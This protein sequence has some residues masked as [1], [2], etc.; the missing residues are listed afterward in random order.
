M[1]MLKLPGLI[2]IHVHLR[3]PGATHKEDFE[4]GSRAAIAGGFTMI[5]DMP[6]N[7]IPT[8]SKVALEDKIKR[9]QKT[10]KITIGFHFGTN[11]KNTDEFKKAWNN[12][13]VFGLKLYC[14][15]TTGEMLLED[16]GLLEKVFAAWKS[17]KP[18][19]VHAEGIELAAAIGLA[20]AYGRRL[21]VCHSSQ[22][23]EVELVR[24]AKKQKQTITAGVCPHHLWMTQEDVKK[25]G[26]LALMKPPLGTKDDQEAL[27]QGLRDGTID[28]IET[29]HA[30][31]TL[32]EKR[33]ETP[34]FGI[35]GLETALGLMLKGVQEKH[36]PL[37][38]VKTLMYSNP[39]KI[40]KI[41]TQ[42]KTYIEIDM[43]KSW[44]VGEKG[45]ESKC[46]WSPFEGWKLPG[47]LQKVVYKGKVVI[48]RV[49]QK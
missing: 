15:H 36:I 13:K 19:L 10:A 2:D 31:H 7:P 34:P 5:I 17:P 6:N 25:I 33:S 27:W 40:F 22:E 9:S 41:P 18:I 14:N 8:I 23:I 20:H 1:K 42:P 11:G 3:D 48:D 38:K 32:E 44:R 47:S 29:D 49:L 21:H 26:S 43:S 16:L 45:Y 35:P 28:I 4:S 37:S 39:K 12:P 46:G 24:Q 30:P